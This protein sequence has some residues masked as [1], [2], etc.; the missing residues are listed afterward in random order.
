MGPKDPALDHKP[1][2]DSPFSW[3]RLEGYGDVSVKVKWSRYRLGLAQRIGRGIAL[4]FHYHSTRRGEWSSAR[5]GHFTPWKEPVP[6]LQEAGWAPGPVWT[7]GKF[8]PHRDS[9]PS[10]WFLQP[11]YISFTMHSVTSWKTANFEGTSPKTWRVAIILRSR[12]YCKT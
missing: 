10:I 9:S 6:I 5:P 1:A 12:V 4:P 3:Y 7:G 2:W 8:R 11:Q